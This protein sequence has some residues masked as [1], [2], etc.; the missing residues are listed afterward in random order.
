MVD[1]RPCGAERVGT[2]PEHDGVP[3]ADHTACVGEHVRAPLE[4]ETDDTERRPVGLD[5]PLGMVDPPDG[6]VSPTR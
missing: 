3:G 5:R 2:D 6:S 1:D 4:H